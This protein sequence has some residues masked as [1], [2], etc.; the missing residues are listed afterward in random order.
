MPICDK[1]GKE[2][3]RWND[4]GL[5]GSEDDSLTVVYHVTREVHLSEL[6]QQKM[7]ERFPGVSIVTD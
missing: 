2:V 7:L 6:Q 4:L 5:I 3:P 1:C